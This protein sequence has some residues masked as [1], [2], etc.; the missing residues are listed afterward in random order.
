MKPKN[1]LGDYPYI[2]YEG[3]EVIRGNTHGECFICKSLTKWIDINF[4]GYL[5]STE[6]EDKAWKD[7]ADACNNRI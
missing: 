6:C 7:Y 2:T 1:G 5:C 3:S 4:E